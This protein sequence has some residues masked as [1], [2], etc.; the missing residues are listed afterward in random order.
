MAPL[1]GQ[2]FFVNPSHTPPVPRWGPF[3]PV[4]FVQPW[5]AEGEPFTALEFTDTLMCIQQL[6]IKRLNRPVPRWE[7]K[8]RPLLEALNHRYVTY[9][10]ALN[11]GGFR[12]ST[13]LSVT[14]LTSF[15]AFSGELAPQKIP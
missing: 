13:V 9:V 4:G 1:S 3:Q 8:V 10:K 12:R 2:L 15:W 5:L 11:R 7:Q 14:I 6:C